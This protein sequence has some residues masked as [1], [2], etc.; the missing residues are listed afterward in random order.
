[1][2]NFS[3]ISSVD[4]TSNVSPIQNAISFLNAC[5]ITFGLT[6][7]VSVIITNSGQTVD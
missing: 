3:Q 7:G 6:Q 2:Q 5:S 4:Q 1:M